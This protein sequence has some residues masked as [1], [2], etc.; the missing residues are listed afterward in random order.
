MCVTD[1]WLLTKTVIWHLSSLQF[2]LS[3]VLFSICIYLPISRLNTFQQFI[4]V[5]LWVFISNSLLFFFFVCVL[6]YSV[7]FI[8]SSSL[9]LINISDLFYYDYISNLRFSLFILFQDDLINLIVG[10]TQFLL[11]SFFCFRLHNCSWTDLKILMLYYWLWS[12]PG[13]MIY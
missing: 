2:L 11:S 7:L 9:E 12:S 13:M 4:N 6:F 3:S 5:Y 10:A 8:S 1:T